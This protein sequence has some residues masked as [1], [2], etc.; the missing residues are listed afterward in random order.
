LLRTRHGR[1]K[2]A[3][4]ATAAAVEA[5]VVVGAQ[6]HG[7]QGKH[8]WQPERCCAS[9]PKAVVYLTTS[10]D[11]SWHAQGVITC[12]TRCNQLALQDVCRFAHL[13]SDAL[14][15]AEEAA[16]RCAFKRIPLAT[17]AHL[18]LQGRHRLNG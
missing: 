18:N 12:G 11:C 16:V 4:T 9:H 6:Q 15:G 7:E 10:G 8:T 17:A 3:A 1:G 14:A 2:T 13:P 5:E